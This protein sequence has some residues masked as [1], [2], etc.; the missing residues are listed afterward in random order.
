MTRKDYI[1]AADTLRDLKREMDETEFNKVVSALI[2][3]FKTDNYRFDAG[4][5]MDWINK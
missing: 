3:M 2:R 5:F 4:R 1:L